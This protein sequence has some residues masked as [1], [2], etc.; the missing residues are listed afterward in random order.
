MPLAIAPQ[1]SSRTALAAIFTALISAF[2]VDR[3]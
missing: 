3:P 2:A 1:T